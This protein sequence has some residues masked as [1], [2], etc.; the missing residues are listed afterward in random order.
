MKSLRFF[1][2]STAFL[3]LALTG[4]EPH[5]F[6]ETKGLHMEHGGHHGEEHGDTHS[7]DE[8]AKDEHAKDGGVKVEAGKEES[9]KTG[10]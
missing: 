4:C 1:A 3:G 6:V 10:I 8:H 9:R 2:L 7:K 5:S